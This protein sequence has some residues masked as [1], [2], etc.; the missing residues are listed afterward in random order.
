MCRLKRNIHWLPVNISQIDTFKAMA[1]AQGEEQGIISRGMVMVQSCRK[2]EE[3]MS[4]SGTKKEVSITAS[5]SGFRLASN[6]TLGGFLIRSCI[7]SSKE[8]CCA[9]LTWPEDMS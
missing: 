1:G 2:G 5:A 9:I 7:A 6:C 8:I 3:L 4:R